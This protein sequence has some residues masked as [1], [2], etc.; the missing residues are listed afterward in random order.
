MLGILVKT[1]NNQSLVF[2]GYQLM[3]ADGQG[4]NLAGL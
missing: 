1:T 4:E 3:E 2:R